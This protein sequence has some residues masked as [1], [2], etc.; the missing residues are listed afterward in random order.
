MDQALALP[1]L[2]WPSS[3]APSSICRLTVLTDPEITEVG[4]IRQELKSPLPAT[5]PSMM[6]FSAFRSPFTEAFWPMVRL[7][8]EL[9][10]PVITPSKIRSVEQFRSPS[11]WMSLD[12]WLLTVEMRYD[13]R[14][15][16][17]FRPHSGHGGVPKISSNCLCVQTFFFEKDESPIQSPFF[18]RSEHRVPPFQ[19]VENW[20]VSAIIGMVGEG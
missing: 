6:A 8:L 4:E 12:R 17:S 13:S 19:Q 10:F 2:H 5:L 20:V 16:L 9:M 18:L 11:I 15:L 1:T 3:G 14:S 7:P